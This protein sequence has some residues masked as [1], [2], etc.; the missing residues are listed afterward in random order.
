M[1]RPEPETAAQSSKDRLLAMV[2][3]GVGLSGWGI[4]GIRSSK[5]WEL[6]GTHAIRGCG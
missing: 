4:Q 6:G 5:S 3:Q 2:R 1:G